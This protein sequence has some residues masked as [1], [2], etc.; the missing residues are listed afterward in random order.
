MKPETLNLSSMYLLYSLLY[1][2]GV[3]LLLPVAA[4]KALRHGKYV[5]GLGERLGTLPEIDAKGREVIWLHCVS[6]G[7]AQAARPLAQAVHENYPNHALVVS[8][9]TLTG[10]RVA[11]ELFS[12]T[13]TKVIYFPFDWAWTVRRALDKINP[14]A[15]LIMETELW[16]RF[17]FE[18]ARRGVPVGLV[19]GRISQK[20][21]S[22]YK[23]IPSFVK[24]IV[25][26]LEIA[27]MQ[28]REDA[29]RMRALGLPV[30][31]IAV[32]GNMKFDVGAS[33]S[34]ER[35]VEEFSKRFASIEKRPL[36]VAASTHAP[37]ER[38]VIEAFRQLRQ[39]GASELRL[40][41]AP[42]HPERFNEVESLVAQSG[43]SWTKRSAASS[44]SD[45]VCDI[46]LLDSI[47]ELRAAY[48]LA[49]IVF[50]GG[51]LA[52]TGGHNLLEPASAGACIITGPHTFNFA[53]IVE[54]F[55]DKQALV[56]VPDVGEAESARALAKVF[57]ELL[58]SPNMR[59]RLAENARGV[60]EAN[61]GA[62][63][64]SLNLLTPILA[65]SSSKP[66]SSK[67]ERA[68]H[69]ALSS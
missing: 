15:V 12:K 24:S 54:G 63:C 43:F 28:T 25:N 23:L 35:L 29:E 57:D 6:V 44:A 18:C 59:K 37:E 40:L 17:L 14:S 30:D 56:E 67:T 31:R 50:V 62:T 42:R 58:A 66:L 27:L 32:S 11:R 5:T 21:F 64:K 49:E 52:H 65:R 4:Y 19:N 3:V 47:G 33:S 2:L 45:A 7:E 61:R 48:S 41:I 46:I 60:L 9:I 69:G 8:T 51:S 36:I 13:A 55:R 53:A 16:P 20:S 10:Q 1:T 26:N 68:R 22:R 38:I 39:N 34:E